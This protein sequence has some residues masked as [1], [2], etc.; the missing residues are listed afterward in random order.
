[1]IS[2]MPSGRGRERLEVDHAPIYQDGRLNETG[3]ENAWLPDG[4]C[5]VLKGMQFA[6]LY[7]GVREDYLSS[8]MIG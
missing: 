7:S 3:S 5:D 8:S 4:E 6:T 2:V 1:M